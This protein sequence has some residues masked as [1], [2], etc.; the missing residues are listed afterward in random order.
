MIKHLINSLAT[1]VA[2]LTLAIGTMSFEVA[3]AD[4]E[5]T[6]YDTPIL[7][8]GL[9]KEVLISKESHQLISNVEGLEDVAY[10]Y[11]K[12]IYRTLLLYDF[13]NGTL[14]NV[15]ALVRRDD[16][17]RF[18]D[19]DMGLIT[20]TLME[21]YVIIT[22]DDRIYIDESGNLVFVNHPKIELVTIIC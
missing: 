10:L 5:S 15:M 19:D 18:S 4:D 13:N 1:I 3:I 2:M 21:N 7:E 22:K 9:S 20:H 11:S 14:A 16:K 17:E 12:G 6:I 8:F